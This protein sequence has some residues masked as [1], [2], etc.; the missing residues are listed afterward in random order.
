MIHLY[1]RQRQRIKNNQRYYGVSNR[2]LY[3]V[4]DKEVCD[5]YD[6]RYIK[7]LSTVL[8]DSDR[9][10]QRHQ[11]QLHF[12]YKTPEMDAHQQVQLKGVFALDL[13]ADAS[14]DG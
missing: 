9:K 13:L 7:R 4:Q 14:R 6:F 8:P 11:G 2:V 10:D 3:I 5:S 1:I 12:E